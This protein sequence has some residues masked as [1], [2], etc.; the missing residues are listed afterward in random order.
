MS[1]FYVERLRIWPGLVVEERIGKSS[2][3]DGGAQFTFVTGEKLGEEP[4]ILISA[5]I[6]LANV[7]SGDGSYGEEILADCRE[8]VEPGVNGRVETEQYEIS[9]RDETAEHLVRVLNKTVLR[10]GE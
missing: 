2:F 7:H 1:P 3:E 4:A 9:H 10:L 8:L 5:Q 6:W